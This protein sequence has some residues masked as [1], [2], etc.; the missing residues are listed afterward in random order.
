MYNMSTDLISM[1]TSKG[2]NPAALS[3]CQRAHCFQEGSHVIELGFTALSP[4]KST[5]SL[6]YIGTSYMPKKKKETSKQE[7]NIAVLFC[8]GKGLRK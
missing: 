4:E 8:S 5:S 1:R 2:A 6:V 7:R 3:A